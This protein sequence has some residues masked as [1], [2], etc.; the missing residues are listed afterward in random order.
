MKTYLCVMDV[1][2]S[3]HY[4]AMEIQAEDAITA[5][6]EASDAGRA[7]FGSPVEILEVVRTDAA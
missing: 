1:L 4:A 2:P 6:R 7:K 5:E 3:G